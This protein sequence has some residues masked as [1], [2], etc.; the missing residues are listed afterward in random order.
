[1]LSYTIGNFVFSS[2]LFCENLK[3]WKKEVFVP[4][5]G[6]GCCERWKGPKL[7]GLNKNKFYDFIKFLE[8]TVV[9]HGD[10]KPLLSKP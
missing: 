3:G 6:E 10:Q 7:K 4:G 1:M 2:L 5:G 8:G 9:D